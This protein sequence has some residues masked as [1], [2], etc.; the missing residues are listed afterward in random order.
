MAPPLFAWLLIIPL[1]F[2]ACHSRAESWPKVEFTEWPS[3]PV[4][5]IKTPDPVVIARSGSYGSVNRD[6][7]QQTA[8]P[9][10]CVKKDKNGELVVSLSCAV[11]Q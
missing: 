2:F 7:R 6:Y 8:I 5:K 1:G 4:S 10:S 3:I 11:S 9:S